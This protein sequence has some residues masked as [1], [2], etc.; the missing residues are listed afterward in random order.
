MRRSVSEE[1]SPAS[2]RASYNLRLGF[3]LRTLDSRQTLDD[4]EAARKAKA[5]EMAGGYRR[6]SF[7]PSGGP[8]HKRWRLDSANVALTVAMAGGRHKSCSVTS[9]QNSAVR[10]ESA[11]TVCLARTCHLWHSV[12]FRQSAVHAHMRVRILPG[13]PPSPD[14]RRLYRGAKKCPYFRG[15]AR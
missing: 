2:L 5:H 6:G 12:I 7:M 14:L 13:Q 3:G 11:Q 1:P 15:F 10:P 8:L 9:R 4:G